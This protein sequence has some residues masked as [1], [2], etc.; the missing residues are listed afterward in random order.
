MVQNTDTEYVQKRLESITETETKLVDFLD[1]FAVLLNKLHDKHNNL[2]KDNADCEDI[3][4][5]IDK[6][7]DDLSYA[8]I[9]LRRELKLLEM[10]LPI[11][12]NL[13]KKATNINNDKLHKLI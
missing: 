1:G 9:H 11:P 7:Y 3:N 5:T 8:S 12:S 6:C 2:S 13:S 4:S 10:N